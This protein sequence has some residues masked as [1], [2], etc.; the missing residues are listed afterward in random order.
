MDGLRRADADDAMLALWM[1]LLYAMAPADRLP[2]E[3]VATVIAAESYL[4]TLRDPS[5]GVYHISR[6]Q[7]TAL[8]MDNVEIYAALRQSAAAWRRYGTTH[9]RAERL[10]ASADTLA[11][12]ID[13]TF[14][15]GGRSEYM[16]STQTRSTPA[17]YPDAVAQTYPW[18]IGFPSHRPDAPP[19]IPIVAAEV[20]RSMDIRRA[21]LSMGVGGAHRG[22]SRRAR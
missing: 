11:L 18:L 17:F 1:H 5:S 13:R 4:D 2:A 20:P 19:G 22:E 8:F 7:P 12:A 3:W 16:V 15:M 10:A 21:R 9:R 14:R 6:A